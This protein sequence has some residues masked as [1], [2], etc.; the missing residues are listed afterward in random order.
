MSA[1]ARPGPRSAS[2][3]T[4]D[5]VTEKMDKAAGTDPIEAV[6]SPADGSKPTPETD[7]SVTDDFKGRQRVTAIE[8]GKIGDPTAPRIRPTA[9]EP[10]CVTMA[11]LPT[12]ETS[13][14]NPACS[15]S[16]GPSFTEMPASQQMSSRRLTSS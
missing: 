5:Q 10:Q 11:M 12:W 4:R 16:C 1:Q 6:D 14:E 8:D 9:A 2:S 15:K 7:K 3:S 13:V